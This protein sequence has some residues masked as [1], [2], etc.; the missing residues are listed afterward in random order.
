MRKYLRIAW[1]AAIGILC[2]GGFFLNPVP[3]EIDFGIP[4]WFVASLA[5]ALAA[6]PWLEW[7]FSLRTLLIV[8][9]VLAIML[10][11]GVWIDS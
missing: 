9:T 10:G 2:V 3:N 6:A 4:Y 5:A 1:S 8:M 11:L 7:R